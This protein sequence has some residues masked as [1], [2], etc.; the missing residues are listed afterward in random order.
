MSMGKVI[1][2]G[3]GPGD[4]GLMTVH[5]LEVLRAADV[6]VY[7]R[8]ANPALLGEVRKDARLIYAGKGPGGM[9]Q[10]QI[11]AALVEQAQAGH[12]VCRLK[13]GDPFLF[14]RGGEEAS[15]LVA[16]G[17]P[18]EVVPGVTSAIAVPAYAGIPVTDRRLAST[19]A[20][21][22][23]HPAEDGDGSTPRWREL[24]G[25]ET[26]VVLMG[27]GALSEV[28][29]DLLAAGRDPEQPAAVIE[30]GT[31][32]RQRIIVGNLRTIAGDA[33]AA[34][35]RPPAI[36]V[37]GRV[38]GLRETLSWVERKPLWG[39]R[40]LVTR[41]A[42]QARPLS[43]ALRDAGAEAIEFPCIEARPLPPDA[44]ALAALERA[45]EWVLFVSANGAD[46][47]AATL[48]AAG[49][50]SRAFPAGRMGAVGPATAAAV[51]AVGL[52]VDFIPSCYTVAAL[53]AELPGELT[54]KAVLLPGR[55]EV[56][57]RLRAGLE[58]RGAEAVPWPVYETVTPRPTVPLADV[59]GDGVDVVT[60]TSPSAAGGFVEL[61]GREAAPDAVVACIGP[62]TAEAARQAG[63]EVAVV[64]EKHTVDGL[65]AAM[66]EHA[67]GKNQ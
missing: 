28:T 19:V 17:V 3:A 62:P 61:G 60:L 29:G 18:F 33:E 23:G 30:R 26:L 4:L 53:A 1:L 49:R 11:N 65:V 50:D 66:I 41:P 25:A 43:V 34:G 5:G 48:R 42:E 47:A 15:Y 24:N 59:V 8:L 32:P 2:V 67:K 39:L 63:L 58:E 55:A 51:E 56:N 44:R 16:H 27:I 21:A 45:Y 37:V 40:V 31:T 7:D 57:P 64:A 20:M 10:G 46:A 6:V 13:G 9:K 54:G 12:V 35:V 38:V 36:L 14:G 22:S 52:R